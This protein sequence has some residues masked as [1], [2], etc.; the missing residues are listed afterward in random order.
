MHNIERLE[1]VDGDFV[2]C[3]R[4]FEVDLA[5]AQVNTRL[6]VMKRGKPPRGRL[7]QHNRLRSRQLHGARIERVVGWRLRPAACQILWIK[8]HGACWQRMFL[9]DSGCAIWEEWS[10]ETIEEELD[11]LKEELKA[12]EDLHGETISTV[13][14]DTPSGWIAEVRIL[15]ESGRAVRLF[16]RDPTDCDSDTLF[17]IRRPT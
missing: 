5:K 12:F 7:Y 8:P 2:A 14:F 6:T 13:V 10:D 1:R 9:D 4:R 11:E 3:L 16:R 15:L 17:E